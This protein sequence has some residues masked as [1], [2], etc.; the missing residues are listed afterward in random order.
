MVLA[1][2]EKRVAGNGM[3]AVL[4]AGCILIPVV[5]GALEGFAERTFSI[6]SKIGEITLASILGVFLGVSVQFWR[7]QVLYRRMEALLHRRMRRA[8]QPG[9][10]GSARAP[11]GPYS[12]R[13]MSATGK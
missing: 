2:V 7:Q 3:A 4:V 1:R 10:A 13:S 6:G 9:F 11:A 12:S 8:L 5:Q